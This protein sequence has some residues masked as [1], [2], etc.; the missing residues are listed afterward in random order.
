MKSSASYCSNVWILQEEN[1][2]TSYFYI[3]KHPGHT[4][5]DTH[6]CTLKHT[7]TYTRIYGQLIET[8]NKTKD[9]S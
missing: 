6:T 1:N 4:H 7:K 8:K 9:I 5:A 2:I 3:F